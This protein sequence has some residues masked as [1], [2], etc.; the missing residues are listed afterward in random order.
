[1]PP[2]PESATLSGVELLLTV[3]LQVAARDPV[4]AGLNVMEAVQVPAAAR[5]VPQV[6]DEIL[7]SL[8]PVPEM[9]PVPSVTE[10]EVPFVIV[11]D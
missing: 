8:A 3:M 9:A 6:V 5:T 1:M 7:K 10:A 11:T 2:V 4:V